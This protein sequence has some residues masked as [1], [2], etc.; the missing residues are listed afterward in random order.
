MSSLNGTSKCN[1]FSTL[2]A[3]NYIAGIKY[4]YTKHTVQTAEVLEGEQN[5]QEQV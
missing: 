5:R 4:L 2:R 1:I 3:C